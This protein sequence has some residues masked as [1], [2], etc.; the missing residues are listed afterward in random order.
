MEPDEFTHYLTTAQVAATFRV[1]VSTVNRWVTGGHLTAS[2]F[3][4][5]RTAPRVFDASV[6]D[7][8]A[9]AL[10]AIASPDESDAA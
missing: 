5:G 2:R 9:A 1:D 7:A 8:F 6:V 10:T 4:S 3:G